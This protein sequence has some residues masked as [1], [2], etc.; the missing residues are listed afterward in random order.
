MEQLALGLEVKSGKTADI[1]FE[2][3]GHTR[4]DACGNRDPHKQGFA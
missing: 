1:Y 3:V 2:P 4:D